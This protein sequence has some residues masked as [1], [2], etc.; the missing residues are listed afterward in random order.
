MSGGELGNVQ[1]RATAS[2]ALVGGRFVKLNT[3][4]GRQDDQCDTQG[5][6]CLG[7][8][9]YDQVAGDVHVVVILGEVEMISGGAIGDGVRV[10]PG[11]DGRVE[12]ALTAD[13]QAGHARNSTAGAG[14]KVRVLVRPTAHAIA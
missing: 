8:V 13:F 7:A 11:A 5:E 1:T 3:T 10:T 6:E 14:E 2:E 12:A 9:E 4:D